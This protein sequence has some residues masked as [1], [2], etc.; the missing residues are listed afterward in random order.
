MKKLMSSLIYYFISAVG[1]SLTIK[2]EIGVSSFNSLNVAVSN[3]TTI[4]VGTITSVINLLFLVGCLVI[5][6]NRK[7]SKYLLMFVTTMSFGMVINFVYYT[8]FANV[9]LVS[10]FLKISVFVLGVAIAGFGTGQVLRINLLTFPIESFCQLLASKTK[11][12]FSNYRYGVDIVC[13]VL[14]IFISVLFSL[15]IVVREGTI[16][17]LFLL[18]G[19][20]SFSKRITLFAK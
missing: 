1:I 10:Y 9:T 19:V 20:I 3:L 11:L 13:V 8:L 17:S 4:Q 18:S 7:L 6:E 15:P 14:S 2:A 12:T 16:F 5:D